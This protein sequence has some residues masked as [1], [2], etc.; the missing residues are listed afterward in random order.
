MD[1]DSGCSANAIMVA[2]NTWTLCVDRRRTSPFA[3]RDEVSAEDSLC[4]TETYR[5]VA[6]NS[7]FLSCK[8]E[9]Q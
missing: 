5:L 3:P 8:I 6:Q 9:Q 7:I 2:H 1:A 4:G